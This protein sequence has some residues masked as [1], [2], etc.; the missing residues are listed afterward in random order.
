MIMRMM[1]NEALKVLSQILTQCL[2]IAITVQHIFYKF[3]NI[4]R[5]PV[6]VELTKSGAS[7]LQYGVIVLY[8]WSAY[9]YR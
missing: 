7:K 1:M 5:L 9:M 8:T 2:K 6:G 4:N 3:L